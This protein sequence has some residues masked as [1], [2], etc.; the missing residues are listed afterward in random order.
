MTDLPL[1]SSVA[2][3]AAFIG[4]TE[5]KLRSRIKAKTGHPPYIKVGG[6]IEFRRDDLLQW[7]ASMQTVK[8]ANDEQPQLLVAGTR[9]VKWP[10]PAGQPA[11]AR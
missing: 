4:W 10:T 11:A 3:A 6:S 8:P 1:L 9:A 5:T 7:Y 2:Q